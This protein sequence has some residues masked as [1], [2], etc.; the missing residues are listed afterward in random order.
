MKAEGIS[1]APHY[2]F[3]TLHKHLDI[4]RAITG[5]SSPLHIVSTAG[6]EPGTFG[7]QAQ[8]ANN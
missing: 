5:E 7:F 4:N 6:L 3:H 2:H 8:L 1:W